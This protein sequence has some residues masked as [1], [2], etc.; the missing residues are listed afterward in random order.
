[1]IR[2]NPV[3]P[4]SRV[5]KEA[6]ALASSGYRVHILAWDRSSSYRE[7]T[8]TLEL[9][10]LSVDITRFG[11]VASFGE[12]FKNLRAF[13]TFQRHLFAWLIK[14]R[15]EYAFIHACDFDT[16]FTSSMANLFLRK[17]LIYDIFDFLSTDAKGLLPGV[18][19]TLES[20][21]VKRADAVIICSEKRLMQIKE[22]FPK[23][24][25]IVHNTPPANAGES[26]AN[27]LIKSESGKTKICYVGIL[28]DYRLLVEM[29]ESV[30]QMTDVELHIGGFGLLE[31][32]FE[33]MSAQDANIFYYGKLSYR[34]TLSLES[35]CDIMTAIYD[36][37]VP[38]HVYAAP[39]K[40][41]EALMLGKPLIMVKGTGMSEVLEA[42][43]IGELID[44]DKVSF[45]Q[46]VRRI[47][48]RRADWGAMSRLSKQL[49]AD[50]YSWD[51]M[52]RRLLDVYSELTPRKRETK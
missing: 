43:D 47:I 1:M 37:V 50:Q 44:F 41:Y 38:N 7:R 31:E 34:D 52:E 25:V 17:R 15:H 48:D 30:S 10:H 9:G 40:F 27:H 18:I 19:R 22:T 5:E 33:R 36:P 51:E 39:N 21:V 42:Y 28:Q 20:W 46:G 35:A 45:S 23:R 26:D 49:Y 12:G 24:I 6:E 11:I 2:S 32:Y 14:H 13:L 4:D 8:S 3:S 29:A 16:A